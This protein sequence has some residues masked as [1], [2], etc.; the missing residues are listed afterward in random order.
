VL[1]LRVDESAGPRV[2][3]LEKDGFEPYVL[4]QGA[5][6]GAV[7]QLAILVPRSARTEPTPPEP[8]PPKASP[9]Q[10]PK[11]APTSSTTSKPPSDIRLER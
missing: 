1:E 6:Q 8:P 2:L 11:R 7:R 9:R 10:V 4:R 5:A 3:V